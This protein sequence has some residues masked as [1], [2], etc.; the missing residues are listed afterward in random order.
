MRRNCCDALDQMEGRINRAL[1]RAPRRTLK[2]PLFGDVAIGFPRRCTLGKAEKVRS[3]FLSLRH[4][5]SGAG[6]FW[7]EEPRN[8]AFFAEV[9][10][11]RISGASSNSPQKRP[12]NGFFSRPFVP[13]QAVSSL[14][15]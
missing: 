1:V 12:E 7:G 3:Q 13:A 4:L 2:S 5:V 8:P 14:I 6:V 10:L 15:S 11:G 9:S